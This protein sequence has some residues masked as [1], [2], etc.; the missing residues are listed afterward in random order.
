MIEEILSPD[1][2]LARQRDE[3]KSKRLDALKQ[4]KLGDRVQAGIT[5]KAG[6]L[7]SVTEDGLVAIRWPEGSLLSGVDASELRHAPDITV[8]RFEDGD[9]KDPEVTH[10]VYDG[11]KCV[12]YLVEAEGG[13]HSLYFV[14]SLPI[15]EQIAVLFALKD[16][17]S[18]HP[19]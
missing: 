2:R 10:Y 12:G 4:F 15:D 7:E 6:I 9:P 13:K 18:G 16:Y 14:I 1:L 17:L 19:I 3:A 8:E 11:I 5:G